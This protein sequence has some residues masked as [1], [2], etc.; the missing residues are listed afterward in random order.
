[1]GVCPISVIRQNWCVYLSHLGL[2]SML[3]VTAAPGYSAV[4]LTLLA[5]WDAFLCDITAAIAWGIISAARFTHLQAGTLG[6]GHC[7]AW[8]TAGESGVLAWRMLPAQLYQP[9]DSS[10]KSNSTSSMQQPRAV[11]ACRG[12]C[13]PDCPLAARPP[14]SLF[15]FQLI[16]P[17]L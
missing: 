2:P 12:A 7:L 8:Q 16:S 11:H 5:G 10:S 15:A 9:L 3:T 6:L 1:M 17:S 13:C 4:L 14:S